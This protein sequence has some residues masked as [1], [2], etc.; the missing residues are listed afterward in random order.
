[1]HDAERHFPGGP[2]GTPDAPFDDPDYLFAH[3]IRSADV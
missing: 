1:M 3:S 2:S